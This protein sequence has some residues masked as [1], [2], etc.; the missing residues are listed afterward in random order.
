MQHQQDTEARLKREMTAITEAAR[1]REARLRESL[2]EA[3]LSAQRAKMAGDLVG[4]ES[5]VLRVPDLVRGALAQDRRE[6][7]RV[8]G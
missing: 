6:V 5:L 7:A 2:D 1:T 4:Y 3:V 8:S